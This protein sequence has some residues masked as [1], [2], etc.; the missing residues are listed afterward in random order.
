MKNNNSPKEGD[1]EGFKAEMESHSASTMHYSDQI[2]QAMAKSEAER[3]LLARGGMLHD[4]GKLDPRLSDL[5]AKPGEWSATERVLGRLHVPYGVDELRRLG[6]DEEVVNFA[7]YHHPECGNQPSDGSIS[8]ADLE[9]IQILTAGDRLSA[10]LVKRKYR[11]PREVDEVLAWLNYGVKDKYLTQDIYEEAESL[12]KFDV[13]PADLDVSVV[14]EATLQTF[15]V[16][17]DSGDIRQVTIL[18]KQLKREGHLNQPALDKLFDTFGDIFLS[19]K[20]EK[21]FHLESALMG[22]CDENAAEK[23]IKLYARAETWEPKVVLASWIGSFYKVKGLLVLVDSLYSHKLIANGSIQ[24]I[25]EKYSLLEELD[26]KSEECE[27]IVSAVLGY[28]ENPGPRIDNPHDEKKFRIDS[29]NRTSAARI[30]VVL[31]DYPKT[32]KESRTRVQ[33]KGDLIVTYRCADRM[34][35]DFVEIP[36]SRFLSGGIN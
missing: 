15:R 23:L 28:L 27:A 22:F 33:S 14:V 12:F 10:G 6:V 32:S 17:S 11:A 35:D 21:I 8:E 13:L 25:L 29:M 31:E 16:S 7:H 26:L 2:L 20:G 24:A 18:M 34:I 19:T 30:L 3:A 9:L 5:F 36:L 1:L 4:I